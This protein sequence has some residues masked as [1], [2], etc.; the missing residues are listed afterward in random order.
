[1]IH[2]FR[3]RSCGGVYPDTQANGSTYHHAC[4]PMPRD[5]KQP[6][7]IVERADKRDERIVHDGYG[8]LAGIVSEGKGVECLTNQALRQQPWLTKL[9]ARAE[10]EQKTIDA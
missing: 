6:L 10:E 4:G 5:R 1:M 9:Y 8:R 7:L 3:C 2:R